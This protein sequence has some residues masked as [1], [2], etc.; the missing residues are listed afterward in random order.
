MTQ[1]CLSFF[2]IAALVFSAKRHLRFLRF[3]QQEAYIPGRFLTWVIKSH[4]FDKRGAAVLAAAAIIFQFSPA[5]A[6]A[7]GGCSLLAIFAAEENPTKRGKLKLKMTD[8]AKRLFGVSFGIYF[9]LQMSLLPQSPLYFW[10]GELIL[11]QMTPLLLALSVWLLN[12]EENRRQQTYL[13][14]AKKSFAAISPYVIGI[15]GSY[16]KTSTKDALGNL[17]QVT[18]G[19]TFWPSKGVNTEMGI[20]KEIRERLKSG[21]KFAVIEMGAYGL[22]S[23]ERLTRLT[24][25]HAGIITTIGVAHLD[26]FGD[27][28]TILL[29]KSELAKAISPDG[30]L[31][32]NGDNLGAREISLNHPK[33]K[34]LL[35]GFDNSKK[36]LDCW[37]Q[38]WK[39][40]SSGTEFSFQWEGKCLSG[41]FPL[42]GKAALSNLAASFSMACALGADPEF[43]IGAAGNLKPVD[44]R[45]QIVIENEVV[46]LKDAYNSNPEGFSDALGVLKGLCA[47]TK[48]LM[49]PGMVELSYLGKELHEKIGRQ[50]ACVCDLAII[51]GS[52]NRESLKS[53]M[54]SGGMQENAII[55][56]E[57]R[58]DAFCKLKGCLRPGDA[59]LI[60]NDL[61]D[62][63]EAKERY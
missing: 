44:N 57:N 49:T 2:I 13:L 15:T 47:K 53:G 35:Y 54:L 46:Y 24:P 50:A 39:I 5:L 62:L 61:P 63:Y 8:R 52:T 10:L 16:G 37:I 4:A 14:E 51:V 34:N 9:F 38:D 17:L 56:A 43:V 6:Y 20:T 1:L 60:E 22:G 3:L 33:R 29:A 27:Q 18:L 45:L 7:L 19:A 48:I 30:I 36:D 59:V 12:G 55:L 31:I 32:C 40:T 11:F 23:I 41:K 28:R 42:V 21:T 58:E 26:R 25:P